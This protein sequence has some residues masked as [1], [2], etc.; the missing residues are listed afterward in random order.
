MKHYIF[1][2]TAAVALATAVF[3]LAAC[4]K[5]DSDST[6]SNSSAQTSAA[7][8]EEGGAGDKVQG[9]KPST[10]PVPNL[11]KP[12]VE[13]LNTKIQRAFD[14]SVDSKEKT[15]WIED[16]DR[17]PYLVD[18]LVAKD[19]AP[20]TIANAILP[21]RAVYRTAIDREEVAVNP[22]AKLAL[23]KDRS[24]LRSQIDECLR[25]LQLSGN[26]DRWNGKYG[27]REISTSNQPD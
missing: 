1:R 8:F 2:T 25:T 10:T 16:A 15:S 5:S 20:S 9:A 6:S 27:L 19:L 17:D 23:P 3:G 13:D 24:A 11:P 21:L 7:A 4:S 22:T 12:T 14:P 18:K 26:L